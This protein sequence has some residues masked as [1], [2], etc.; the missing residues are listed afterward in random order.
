MVIPVYTY[1]VTS[2]SVTKGCG[3]HVYTYSINTKPIIMQSRFYISILLIVSIACHRAAMPSATPVVNAE[4]QNDRKQTILAGHCTISI[5]QAKNYKEWYDKSYNAYQTDTNTIEQLK[6]LLTGKTI[7]IFMGSWCGDSKREVP[8]MYKILQQAGMDTNQVRLIFVDN[9]LK[10]YK[11]SP[12]HEEQGKNIHHV[13]TMIV[14]DGN[15]EKGRII[16]SPV[17]SLEKDLLAI[18][19]TQTYT[20]NYKAVAWWL[21]HAKHKTHKLKNEQLQVMVTTLQP[22]CK[23]FG[24]FNAYGYMLLAKKNYKEAL[25]VFR[26]NTLLYPAYAGAYDSLG[27]VYYTIGDIAEA[28]KNYEKVLSMQPDNANAKKMLEKMK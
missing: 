27:E 1:Q 21:A 9:S 4:I 7:E 20:P 10:A 5:L 8:R 14:Y 18:L 11:Q 19:T 2:C 28:R 15:K 24:E 3:V 6:P 12:Q 17:V 25:N 13:P 23:D 26:L 16:E 22:L